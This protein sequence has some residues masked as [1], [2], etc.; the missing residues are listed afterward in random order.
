[1]EDGQ[2]PQRSTALDPLLDLIGASFPHVLHVG[3]PASGTLSL[4]GR[5]FS[6]KA[7]PLKAST[8][9]GVQELASQVSDLVMLLSSCHRFALLSGGFSKSCSLLRV[10]FPLVKAGRPRA[11]SEALHQSCQSSSTSCRIRAVLQRASGDLKRGSRPVV[12]TFLSS[13]LALAPLQS[14]TI[15]L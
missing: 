2:I 1:M 14:T 5:D 15:F 10:S 6:K 8:S 12:Q 3:F 13:L 11:S 9:P 4:L 7:R